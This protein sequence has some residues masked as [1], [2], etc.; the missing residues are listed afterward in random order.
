MV[1][2]ARK[3][4]Q[5]FAL[6][7]CLLIK[8][9]APLGKASKNTTAF[10]VYY[11]RSN[12]DYDAA[13]DIS[14]SKGADDEVA[15]GGDTVGSNAGDANNNGNDDDS[16]TLGGGSDMI[17]DNVADLSSLRNFT[18]IPSYTEAGIPGTY[19]DM[20]LK[21]GDTIL[22]LLRV[23]DEY[24]NPFEDLDLTKPPAFTSFTQVF[25]QLLA[26]VSIEVV[27]DTNSELVQQESAELTVV[28]AG[29]DNDLDG[30]GALEANN[31]Y[32]VSFTVFSAGNLR[33]SITL[34]ESTGAPSDVGGDVDNDADGDGI[35]DDSIGGIPFF[36][37]VRPG[38]AY[39]QLSSLEQ[40]PDSSV[41]YAGV[42]QSFYIQCRDRYSNDL[43]EDA[44]VLD[45]QTGSMVSISTKL[46]LRVM[47]GAQSYSSDDDNSGNDDADEA[48]VGT[49]DEVE[50]G[51]V[52]RF[53]YAGRGRY[54]V[55][56]VLYHAGIFNCYLTFDG[57]DVQDSPF[58]ITIA[59]GVPSHLYTT[60]TL[61][62]FVVSRYKQM[63]YIQLRDRFDNLIYET[64]PSLIARSIASFN[65]IARVVSDDSQNQC[66]S[67]L[68]AV[69]DDD[70][71]LVPDHGQQQQ[72]GAV[73]QQVLSFSYSPLYQGLYFTSFS[74]LWVGS[75]TLSILY[76]GSHIKGS[77]HLL[78]SRPGPAR[79]KQ[80][81]IVVAEGTEIDAMTGFAVVDTALV[82]SIEMKD[83]HSFCLFTGDINTANAIAVSLKLSPSDVRPY[84]HDIDAH[85]NVKSSDSGG[86][87]VE[88][89]DTVDSNST[90]I[91]ETRSASSSSG[92]LLPE[93]ELDLAKYPDIAD[94]NVTYIGDNEYSLTFTMHVAG[95]A[96]LVLM[97]EE[98]ELQGSPIHL[99][100]LPGP[101]VA[102]REER[103]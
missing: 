9:I 7:L 50:S 13:V 31:A 73:Q 41:L 43:T 19:T 1:V 46:T 59:A 8:I 60:A 22:A 42:L 2:R 92:P 103:F 76:D 86:T 91:N 28:Y 27:D 95:N 30:D 12:I 84:M 82:F 10:E 18:R 24:G 79:G 97:Y 14:N 88:T 63:V 51:S 81:Q 62:D 16:D 29:T 67:S 89:A 15:S 39:A 37:I 40:A 48:D 83:F 74:P 58:S 57:R 101:I 61:N 20:Q 87:N 102:G 85:V 93:V 72:E 35:D 6:P 64:S 68:Q 45:A 70:G 80:S 32:Y 94:Q 99:V 56:Y 54:Q 96:T 38:Q 90:T 44:K 55:D 26:S 11:L 98:E 49:G 34:P 36:A 66:P 4:Y 78:D 17:I 23:K 77:P 52:S 21:A 25:K 71:K 33:M 100:M 53:V 3:R 75:A 47:G 69:Y 5:V 65:A